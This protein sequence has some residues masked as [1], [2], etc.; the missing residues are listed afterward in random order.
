M[1]RVGEVFEKA[2]DG[3][4]GESS[5]E[6]PEHRLND[7]GALELVGLFGDVEA[8]DGERANEG[9]CR[10]YGEEIDDDAGGVKMVECPLG[11][12]EKDKIERPSWGRGGRC[13]GVRLCCT[14]SIA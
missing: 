11:D 9:Q 8:D 1:R 3:A 7:D 5:A 4:D 2:P 10:E 12:E 13:S 14:G 6:T